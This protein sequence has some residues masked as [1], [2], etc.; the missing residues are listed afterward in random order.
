VKWVHNYSQSILMG[1]SLPLGKSHSFRSWMLQLVWNRDGKTVYFFFLNQSDFRRNWSLICEWIPHAKFF[2]T[3]SCWLQWIETHMG[4]RQIVHL[5][6]QMDTF[7][8]R[9]QGR[10]YQG[11]GH[12]LGRSDAVWGE[13]VG[14][15]Q[16][17]IRPCGIEMKLKSAVR[18]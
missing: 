16:N 6:T 7:T 12:C 1:E 10:L 17:A 15:W 8:E 5:S 14:L 3:S 9:S 11:D 18:I 4:F 2:K 13:K